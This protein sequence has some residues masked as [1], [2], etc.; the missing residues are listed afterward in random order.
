MT[1][2]KY[3]HKFFAV[4]L[5]A[6][7]SSCAEE[8]PA[9]DD[10]IGTKIKVVEKEDQYGD[11]FSLSGEGYTGLVYS[12]STKEN[13]EILLAELRK[14]NLPASKKPLNRKGWSQTPIEKEEK[15]VTEI[16]SS[17]F[18]KDKGFLD[19]QKKIEEILQSR[20][21]NYYCYYFK[22][23]DDNIIELELYLIDSHNSKLY[24]VKTSV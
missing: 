4:I 13:S 21:N 15:Q 6:I 24:I 23:V 2:K 5:I 18:T 9:L 3:L 1:V 10:I 11:S 22:E 8:R 19:F 16:C 7:L 14:A 17:Y 20:G 12:I